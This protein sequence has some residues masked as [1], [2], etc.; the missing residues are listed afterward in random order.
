LWISFKKVTKTEKYLL[1]EFL[2]SSNR[3]D[4]EPYDQL[5]EELNRSGIKTVGQFRGFIPIHQ[6]KMLAEDK[7]VVDKFQSDGKKSQDGETTV[8]IAGKLYRGRSSRI[9]RGVFLT[10]VGLVRSMLRIV[11]KR[12]QSE[13]AD[14]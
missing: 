13:Q 12:K 6:E 2:P 1:N 9:D 3:A 14:F 11:K 10:H 5:L 8:S 4:D 7:S